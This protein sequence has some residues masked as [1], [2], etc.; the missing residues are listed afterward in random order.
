MFLGM[1]FRALSSF[2]ESTFGYYKGSFAVLQCS[3]LSI[4]SRHMETGIISAYKVAKWE[5][6]N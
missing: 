3:E 2:E 1:F 6:V 5:H 4:A